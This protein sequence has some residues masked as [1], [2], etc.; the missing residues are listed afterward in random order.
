M[1]GMYDV[2]CVTWSPQGKLFQVDYAKEAVKHGGLTLGLRSKTHTVDWTE[3]G[4]VHHKAQPDS[5][6]DVPGQDLQSRQ[7]ARHG[8]LGPHLGRA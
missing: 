5:A 1:K 8:H 2:D 4:L 6:G 7:H 3:A